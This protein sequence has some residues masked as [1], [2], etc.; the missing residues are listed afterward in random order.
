MGEE[1][2]LNILSL[3]VEAPSISIDVGPDMLSP[4]T[5]VMVQSSASSPNPFYK[6]VKL[7]VIRKEIHEMVSR[8]SMISNI[9]LRK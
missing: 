3:D 1:D 8:K 9:L 7:G 4:G 6:G 2:L 5:L